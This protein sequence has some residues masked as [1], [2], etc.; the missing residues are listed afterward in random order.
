M[1]S[2]TTSGQFTV[3]I[4]DRPVQDAALELSVDLTARGETLLIL[5]AAG[6]F[7]PVRMSH[8]APE[9]AKRLQIQRVHASERAGESWCALLSAHCGSPDRRLLVVGLLDCLY[10]PAMLTRDAARALGR[11]KSGLDALVAG[12]ADVTVVCEASHNSGTRAHFLSS[13][14]VSADRKVEYRAPLA[15]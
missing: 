12:G 3:C 11:I 13:L 1:T 6:C 14:C 7:D 8:A 9:L 15:S 10:D 4:T 2:L 5:D